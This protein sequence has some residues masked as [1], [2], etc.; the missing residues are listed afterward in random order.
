MAP[1]T[2]GTQRSVYGSCTRPQSAWLVD[3][4]AALEQR[5]QARGDG[6]LAGVPPQVVDARVERRGGAHEGLERERRGDDR[7]VEQPARVAQRERRRRPPSGA[8]R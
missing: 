7:R 3:D 2:C 8:C 5:P 1:S 4:R 6:V